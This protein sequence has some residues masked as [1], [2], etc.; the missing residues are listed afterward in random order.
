MEQTG[1]QKQPKGNSKM[2]E[3]SRLSEGV[4]CAMQGRKWSIITFFLPNNK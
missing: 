3:M 4:K 1:Y 2:F